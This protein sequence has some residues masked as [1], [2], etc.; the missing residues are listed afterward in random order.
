ML[1]TVT[2]GIFILFLHV[3]MNEKARG[4]VMRW[5][6]TGGACPCF[7]GAHTAANYNSKEYLSSQL[8]FF[9]APKNFLSSKVEAL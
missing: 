4:A 9:S 1:V 2:Q 8:R 7:G 5:L 3:V 6:R